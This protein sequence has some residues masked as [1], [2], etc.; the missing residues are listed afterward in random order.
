MEK[1][2]EEPTMEESKNPTV[3]PDQLKLDLAG[4][5]VKKYMYWSMGAGL[6]PV[7][8]LDMATV[9]GV[10]LKM[11]SEISKIY[12]VKFSENA[13][14]SIIAALLGSITAGALTRSTLTSF[15]KSIPIIGFLGSLSMPI[16]SGAATWAIGKVFIQHFAT[17]GTFLNFDPQKVKDY[18]ADLYKQGQT[19]A[20]NIKSA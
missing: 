2:K 6:I 5:V 17:G 10:Q 7:P 1:K 13:G 9:S 19:V 18:F 3:E 16:Y 14:K 4:K 11:L 8:V 20:E 15:I 12:D